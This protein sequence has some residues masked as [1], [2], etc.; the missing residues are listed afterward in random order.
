[1]VFEKEISQEP[2]GQF[3]SNFVQTIF[4]CTVLL[5]RIEHCSNNG[6]VP[7]QR[8][9]NRKNGVESLKNPCKNHLARKAQIYRKAF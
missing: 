3:Q 4:G 8:G 6:S 5:E 7:F 1:V 9:R 2:S